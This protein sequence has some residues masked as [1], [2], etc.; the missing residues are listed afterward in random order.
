MYCFF[1]FYFNVHPNQFKSSG[2]CPHQHSQCFDYIRTE[3]EYRVSMIEILFDTR[4]EAE[5]RISTFENFLG[6]S[7]TDRISYTDIHNPILTKEIRTNIDFDIRNLILTFKL[8]PT[9]AF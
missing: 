6:H 4:A 9:I 3:A 7:S 8:R 5:Y 2:N 1:F